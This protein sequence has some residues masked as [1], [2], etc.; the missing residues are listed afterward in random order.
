MFCAV[1]TFLRHLYE[2]ELKQG[3]SV[4]GAK[5]PPCFMFLKYCRNVIGTKYAHVFSVALL[6]YLTED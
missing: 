1:I 4:L 3:G 6:I 2:H 5:Q